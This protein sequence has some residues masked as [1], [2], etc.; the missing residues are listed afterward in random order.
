M[1]RKAGSS[2]KFHK[3]AVVG[4]KEAAV[5]K[6]LRSA[7]EGLRL[8]QPLF[9]EAIDITR[10]R[11]ATYEDG[12]APVRFDIALR[13]CRYWCISEFW[14]AT[15]TTSEANFKIGKS[16]DFA[17]IDSR[18]TM[19]L[20]VHPVAATGALGASLLERFDPDI[21]RAYE[22][23]L[24]AQ[25]QE[26]GINFPRIRPFPGDGYGYYAN[27]VGC[28]AGFLHKGLNEPQWEAF[29][30]TLAGKAHKLFDAR[31]DFEKGRA[32]EFGKI[33]AEAGREK[34]K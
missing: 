34:V 32:Y 28:V 13:A 11:L 4:E 30:Q 23:V 25:F 24:D 10:E 29:L 33:L 14:L 5:A 9:A 6:R 16:S 22:S 19:A 8:T 3:A 1:R 2:S 18:L 20:A 15:G 12:R 27:W 31:R 7:R 17:D 21:R 26:H